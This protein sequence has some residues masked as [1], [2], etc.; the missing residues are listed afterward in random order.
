MEH[1]I[2]G[3]TYRHYSG[4]LYELIEVVTDS[5]TFEKQVVYQELFEKFEILVCHYSV[6]TAL[7]PGNTLMPVFE[8]FRSGIDKEL[9]IK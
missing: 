1:L 4:K 8:W 2:V 3:S 9:R 5:E 6:F 7:V